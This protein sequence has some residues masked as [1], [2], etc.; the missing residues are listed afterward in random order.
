M[1]E[2]DEGIHRIMVAIDSSEQSDKAVSMASK[3]ARKMD[4][5]LVLLHVIE[6]REVPSLIA[7]AEEKEQEE[8]GKTVLSDGAEIALN[9]GVQAKFE[10]RRGHAPGQI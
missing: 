10:L 8:R 5:E 6:L 9:E 4:A 7:E 2:D 3:I 1:N